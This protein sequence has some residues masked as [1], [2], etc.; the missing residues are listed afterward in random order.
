ML[1][2]LISHSFWYGVSPQISKVLSFLLL[3]ILTQF[4]TPVDFGIYGVV[5]AYIVAFTFLKSLGLDYHFANVFIAHPQKYKMVWSSLFT[6]LF[7]W[8]IFIG[9]A[10]STVLFFSIPEEAQVNRLEIILLSVIPLVFFSSVENIYFRYHQ[11]S[12]NPKGIAFRTIVVGLSNVLISFILIVYFDQG[13]MGWFFAN[14][15][16]FSL[17]FFISFPVVFKLISPIFKFSKPRLKSYFEK[18]LPV[19]PHY[20]GNYLLDSSDRIV[21]DL[22]NVSTSD[23]GRYNLSYTLANAFNIMASAVKKAISPILLK[24]YKE[25]QSGHLYARQLTFLLQVIFLGLS[26]IVAIWSDELL[27]IFITNDDFQNI[28]PVFVVILMSFNY[29][30]M[31]IGANNQLFY[32]GK[33]QSLW[34]R[35]LIAASI[36]IGLNVI[37]IP[38]YGILAA[39]IS[40]FFAYMFL[41]YSTYFM[42][43]YKQLNPLNYYPM[44]WLLIT[45][46]VSLTVFII[47]YSF[48]EIKILASVSIGLLTLIGYKFC[49]NS[50][51][52]K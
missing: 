21:M 9:L 20:Y 24:K 44:V 23:I 47:N 43:D 5:Q 26:S 45:V 3:P 28:S 16:S 22:L 25:G 12:E 31:Y 19:L 46:A 33:V 4:L 39:A 36:N 30:P 29:V 17:G 11:L 13:Y 35:A 34:K 7:I 40:T 37:F 18:G 27:R 48:M 50:N 10:L 8:G 38:L 49:A 6:F 52:L 41:G 14:F 51:D 15:I 42:K 2:R 1:R 32:N